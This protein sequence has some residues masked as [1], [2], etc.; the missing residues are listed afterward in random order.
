MVISESSTLTP[1]QVA[2]LAKVSAE[3]GQSIAGYL[4][5]SR[6]ANEN[7]A[8]HMKIAHDLLDQ[9]APRV[10]VVNTLLFAFDNIYAIYP[11]VQTAGNLYWIRAMFQEASGHNLPEPSHTSH[12]VADAEKV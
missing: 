6:K 11:A 4:S 2:Q 10:S 3:K 7:F 12:A 9:G 8:M 5:E 1:I